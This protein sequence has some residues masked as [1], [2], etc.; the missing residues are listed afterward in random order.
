VNPIFEKAISDTRAIGAALEA[1]LKR[2]DGLAAGTSV[3]EHMAKVSA[4]NLAELGQQLDD[5]HEQIAS[6]RVELKALSEQA[7]QILD[8]ARNEADVIKRAADKQAEDII[9]TARAKIE[10]AHAHLA[11]A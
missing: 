10:K 8:K 3:A 11:G 7:K 1:E 6:A 5:V 2:L 9:Q 4:G